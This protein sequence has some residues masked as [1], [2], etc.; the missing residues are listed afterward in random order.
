[1][2]EFDPD[3]SSV[4]VHEAAGTVTLRVGR[5]GGDTGIVNVTYAT[6]NGSAT[7]GSD[8]T[9]T[10]ATLTWQAGET[11]LKTFTVPILTDSAVE[12]PETFTVN[13]S[14]PTGG[15]V[16]G[17]PATVTVTITDDDTIVAVQDTAQTSFGGPVTIYPTENDSGDNLTI[18]SVT[19][20]A[21][22]TAAINDDNSITYTPDSAFTGEDRFDY[23]VE[24]DAGVR[25]T[26]TI[27]VRVAAQLAVD[28]TAGTRAAVPV[29]IDVL[30][31]DN[32]ADLSIVAV[33]SPSFGTAVLNKDQ[34]ITYTP[35]SGFTGQDA[36]TYTVTDRQ[37]G[38]EDT[39]TVTVSVGLS[40]LAGLNGNQRSV[41]V[42]L[43]DVCSGATGELG[44]RCLELQEELSD[45]E[46]THALDEI[47]PNKV[48]VQGR[49]A[50]D[51][52]GTQMENIRT[53]L[54]VVRTGVPVA[55]FRGLSMNIRGSSVPVEAIASYARQ[56]TGGPTPAAA[57]QNDPVASSFANEERLGFFVNGRTD[58]GDKD[59]TQNETGYD[60][61]SAG[62]TLGVDYRFTSSAIFGGSL[63]YANSDSDLA[64]SGGA[65]DGKAWTLSAYGGYFPSLSAYVDW[66]V[67]VGTMD[68]DMTRNIV[69]SGVNT[70][71]AGTTDGT[72]YG[73]SV[74]GGWDFNRD[75]W[76][77]SPYL[78]VDFIAADIDAY[79]ETG[80]DGLAL[81]IGEQSVDS[82]T[83]A[84]S[85]RFSRAFSTSWGVVT[86]GL[87]VEWAHEYMDDA[88]LI[89]STFVQDPTTAFAIST[90]EPDRDYFNAAINVAIG[91]RGG[92]SFFVDYERVVGLSDVT[93]NTINIGYRK[94]F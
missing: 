55:D 31:N 6:V 35:D 45:S 8:Y 85:G 54:A 18:V 80:G 65:L 78:R 68:F 46:V 5:S 92:S 44:E 7:A 64:G 83:S 72:Q 42:A 53:R 11:G 36:F 56:D 43:D 38:P 14:N 63:G 33:G 41:A 84:L 39:A 15:A 87:R 27:V 47:S 70:S 82:L 29:T 67:S 69:Y 58:F 79:S 94:Q 10:T 75:G 48:A 88:M 22:G 93:S 52:T 81:S 66:L 57:P 90:D 2:V 19:A 12:E 61:T 74:S 91:L 62:I 3:S 23:T 50:M 20:P 9:S 21:H 51:V 89:T 59:T 25:A 32:G 4:T 73:A 28:D 24:N 17:S 86:P 1:V 26:A 30:A 76:M 60:F 49:T 13:L 71:T 40:S 34:T 77:L 16:I 37:E